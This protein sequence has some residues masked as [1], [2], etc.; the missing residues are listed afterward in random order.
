M[1]SVVTVR[2]IPD[3][4]A[5]RRKVLALVLLS[6][7]LSLSL[8][9]Q[10]LRL[11]VEPGESGRE[12]IL[13]AELESPPGKEPLALQWE[14]SVPLTLQLDPR[15]AS[16]GEAAG[17]AQKSVWCATQVNYSGSRIQSCRCIL[18][19]GL[20]AIPNGR[21]AIVKYSSARRTKAGKYDIEIQKAFAVASG[22]KKVPLKNVQAQIIIAK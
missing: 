5:A 16:V 10:Q 17:S 2:A 7:L 21:V 4:R 14:F 20:G 9:A 6:L 19:G 18:A 1:W 12:G 13:V 3:R 22:V 11:R 15:S 8:G